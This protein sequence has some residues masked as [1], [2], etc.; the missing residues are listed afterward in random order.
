MARLISMKED[1]HV[2]FRWVDMYEPVFFEFRIE[3]DELT[4]DLALIITDFAEDDV[5]VDSAKLLWKSQIE[6]L[7]HVLGA[8]S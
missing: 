2:R 1:H 6:A 8:H 5:A 7:F 3:V 4:G